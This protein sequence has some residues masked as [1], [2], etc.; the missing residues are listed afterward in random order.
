[1]AAN[2]QGT[3]LDTLSLL[4]DVGVSRNTSSSHGPQAGEREGLPL[5]SRDQPLPVPFE[6]T[7]NDRLLQQSLRFL[8]TVVFVVSLLA[9]IWTF[10][11]KGTFDANQKNLFNVAN[12]GLS[13]GLGLNVSVSRCLKTDRKIV[14]LTSLTGVFQRVRKY[15]ETEAADVGPKRLGKERS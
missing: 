10:H 11:N 5:P 6:P 9:T 15:F 2:G 1:M 12:L 8:V 13:L 7:F 14:P 3:E 4:R